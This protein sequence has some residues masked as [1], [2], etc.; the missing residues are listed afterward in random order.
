MCETV[1]L[2][3][4]DGV[5]ANLQEGSR[6]LEIYARE[7]S[8]EEES[9]SVSGEG[10]RPARSGRGTGVVRWQEPGSCV[11]GVRGLLALGVLGVGVGSLVQVGL[12][13][14]QLVRWGTRWARAAWDEELGPGLGAMGT[15]LMRWG[16]KQER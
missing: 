7:K 1:A 14:W 8:C 12:G 6:F 16:W 15:R 10:R 11:R 3:V 13:P 4:R 9:T 2:C 5:G